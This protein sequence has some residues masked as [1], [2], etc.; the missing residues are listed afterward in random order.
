[1]KKRDRK[2]PKLPDFH[3]HE[4]S[5]WVSDADPRKLMIMCS[6]LRRDR[7]FALRFAR[8]LVKFAQEAG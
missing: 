3:S 4:F 1:M 6:D 8:W 2:K 5:A 7:R